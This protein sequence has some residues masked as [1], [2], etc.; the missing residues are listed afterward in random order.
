[1]TQTLIEEWQPLFQAMTPNV[2]AVLAL[3]AVVVFRSGL[4]G[5]LSPLRHGA[6]REAS[7]L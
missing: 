1:M 7:D 4:R 5:F 2:L 6:H 3:L